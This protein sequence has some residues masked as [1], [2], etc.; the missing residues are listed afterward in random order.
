MSA[1]SGGTCEEGYG[2]L[3][4]SVTH[5]AGPRIEAC[6]RI[7]QRCSLCGEKLCDS[8]GCAMPQNKDGS[9]PEFST[10]QVGRLVRVTSGWPTCYELLEDESGRLPGD[11]CLDLLED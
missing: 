9:L 11:S 7:V 6:G 1:S 10:W 2:V 4:E 8:K 5:I 3:S